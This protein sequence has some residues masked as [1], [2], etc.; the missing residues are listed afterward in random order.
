MKV[1]ILCGGVGSRIRDA[2]EA[3]PKPML[4]IGGKPILWHIMKIFAHHGITEFILCLGYKGW[5]IKEF[6]LD[7]QALLSD[8]TITLGERHAIEFHDRVSEASWRVTCA[9]T[10]DT[11]MTGGRL[12]QAQKYLEGE[13]HFCFTYGDA[14]GD[15]D[16]PALIG[17]HRKSGLVGTLTG[18]QVA[19]RFGELDIEKNLV[20]TFNEKPAVTAGRISGG[21]MVFDNRRIWQYLDDDPSLTL[22][23]RP[24]QRLAAD[25]QLGVYQHDGYWQ[26]M[27]TLR[28]YNVLNAAWATASPPWKIWS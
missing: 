8:F 25:H 23:Q 19:G 6:F 11:T 21:F 13:E 14:V 7:Y 12:W 3:L 18:V 24:L 10:G 16:I 15:I 1:V 4:P 20:T 5:L 28:D 17:Q 26:C 27:D 9:E 2:S 22:E